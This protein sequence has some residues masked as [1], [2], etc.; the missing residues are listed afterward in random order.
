M[1]YHN[2]LDQ[3]GQRQ[4]AGAWWK[5]FGYTVQAALDVPLLTLVTKITVGIGKTNVILQDPDANGWPYTPKSNIHNLWERGLSQV[6]G[7]IKQLLSSRKRRVC[8]PSIYCCTWRGESPWQLVTG[9][10]TFYYGYHPD[11]VKCYGVVLMILKV[12]SL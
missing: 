9:E 8:S 12:H 3:K 11:L 5:D 2:L 10:N 4:S 7:W 1:L 6:W